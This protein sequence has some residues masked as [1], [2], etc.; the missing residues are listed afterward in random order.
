MSTCCTNEWVD[1]ENK[2]LFPMSTHPTYM[3]LEIEALSVLK[4]SVR[5]KD[6]DWGSPPLMVAPVLASIVG[7]APHG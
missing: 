2:G 3:P 1:V 5:L 4:C 7:I 6:G